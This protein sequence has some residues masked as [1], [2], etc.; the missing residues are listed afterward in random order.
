M[1]SRWYAFEPELGA[2]YGGLDLLIVKSE[3]RYAEVG[4]EQIL[5][6]NSQE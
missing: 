5:V 6:A 1:E 4:S 2:D 3:Q